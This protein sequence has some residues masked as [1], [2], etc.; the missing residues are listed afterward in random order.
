ML[1]LRVVAGA[2]LLGAVLTFVVPALEARFSGEFEDFG[3]QRSAGRAVATG[4]NPYADFVSLSSRT[5]V[6]GLGFDYPPLVAWLM[7]PFAGMSHAAAVAVWLLLGLAC[8]IGGSVVVC[9]TLLPKSWPATEIGL[10]AGLVFPPAVY[11]LWHGN[12]NVVVFL[13]TALALREWVRGNQVRCGLLLGAGAA[14][15]LAPIVLLVL[16]VRRRWWRGTAS[17]VGLFA[18]TLVG[19]GLLVGHGALRTFVGSVLPVLTRDDGW[20]QNQSFNAVLSRLADR[21]VLGV[22]GST[23]AVHLTA[24]LLAAAALLAVAWQVRPGSA[25]AA[26]RGGEFGAGVLAMLLSG[27]ITW[28]E[29]YGLLLIPLAACAA[30]AISR[31][32][33][34]V[35]SLIIAAAV[36][37]LVFAVVARSVIDRFQ[38]SD[39]LAMRDSPWWWP[40]LQLF[41]LP[42]VSA[43]A[44]LVLLLATLSRASRTAA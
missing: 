6:R 38:V 39:A 42:A 29:H 33:R 5:L 31:P 20:L 21:N 22:D 14:L 9:R 3:L 19:G 28:Y 32:R 23:A 15:K 18:A 4:S 35:R 12:L 24:I 8:L 43:A 27:T 13:F 34:E 36:V 37:A 41:S 2:A 16:F 25:P 40:W 1:L 11:N 26:V 44:L 10:A 7:Q 17:G 30:V